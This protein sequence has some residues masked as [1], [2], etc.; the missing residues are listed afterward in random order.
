MS[1]LFPAMLVGAL[2]LGVPVVMHLIARH[3]F[4]VQD[5]PTIRLL[6]KQERPNI[7]AAKLVDPLQLLLRLLVMI[8][9]VLAMSRLFAGWVTGS[10]APRNVV[11]VIDTSASMAMRPAPPATPGATTSPATTGP[12]AT[13]PAATGPATAPASTAARPTAASA[14]PSRLPLIDLARAQARRVAGDLGP[15]S[16]CG[17]VADG[18]VGPLDL[19]PTTAI[20][21]VL[22][23]VDG[24][25][26]IDSAGRGLVRSI[27]DACDM[28]RGRRE[29]RTQI[30]ILTDL[31]ASA[32]AGRDQQA[33]DRIAAARRDLGSALEILLVDLTDG[34]PTNVGVVNVEVRGG[35]VRVGEDAH[36]LA[37]ILNSSREPVAADVRLSIADRRDAQPRR[38]NLEP[39]GKAVV[40]LTSRVNRSMQ[41][42]A[43][44]EVDADSFPADDALEAP[45]NV[46]DARH[47]LIVDGTGGSATSDGGAGSAGPD[48]IGQIG[49]NVPKPAAD[50]P[51]ISGATILR[52]ALNPGREI[53]QPYGTGLDATLVSPEALA[54]Q[55]LSK[56]S[57]VILYD[58]SSLSQQSMDDLQTF[59]EQGR[60]LLIIC[61]GSANAM[62]FNRS[63]AA[64]AGPATTAPTSAASGATPATSPAAHAPLAPAQ[65][66][67][68]RDLENA[69]SIRLDGGKHPLLSPFR[70]PLQGDVSIVRFQKLRDVSNIQEGA[71]V[72]IRGSGDQPLAIEMPRG[73]GRVMMLTFGLE[74]SRGNIA[75]TRVFPVLLWRLTDYLTGRLRTIPPA[76]VTAMRPAALD[77]SD[78]AFALVQELELTPVR[79][80]GLSPAPGSG[81]ATA[82]SAGASPANPPASQPAP[83]RSTEPIRLPLRADATVLLPPLPAG[84]YSLHKA[85]PPGSSGA[86]GQAGPVL[87]YSRFVIARPDAGESDMTPASTDDIHKL[88]G[89]SARVVAPAALSNLAPTGGELTR[90][91]AFAAILFLAVEAVVGW[92]TG[93]RRERARAA[94]GAA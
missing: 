40:D 32:L 4:A 5:L 31:R 57:L 12:A 49:G 68:D 63:L 22:D 20:A 55:P 25:T 93:V 47:V 87:G 84:R 54:G 86:P 46:I 43:R 90:L 42:V 45:L 33:I 28:V 9:I 88:L 41:N 29:V 89:E 65:L 6:D 23:K 30:V 85:S 18:T 82:P 8:A 37:T 74:L 79:A 56:Y 36:V 59:V 35:E 2:G 7:L 48:R 3:R 15:G 91:L 14:N 13:A 38:V 80:P 19:A 76:V 11:L 34:S 53:G 61:S 66:G 83:A 10:P 73:L 72:A 26:T 77:A 75:R 39:G 1:F 58:V 27:A 64:G 16:R 69:A 67:N 21:S 51:T 17:L 92:I 94:E 71:T 24:L 44:A 60:A 81:A 78:P 70:D 50:E 52:M 62:T